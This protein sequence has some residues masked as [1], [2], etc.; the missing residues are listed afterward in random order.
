MHKL[1]SPL[2][3]EAA[4]VLCSIQLAL[5]ENWEQIIIEGDAKSCFDPLT[6]AEIQ[7][8]WSIA[9]TVNNILELRNFYLNCNFIGLDVSI[10]LHMRLQSMQSSLGLS[11][12]ISVVSL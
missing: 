12:S 7:S 2:R 6:I 1:C 5:T 3:A 9:T 10:L 4:A 8:D 11:V